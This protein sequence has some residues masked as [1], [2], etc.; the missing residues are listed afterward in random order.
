[1]TQKYVFLSLSSLIARY[2]CE[3]VQNS[4]NDFIPCLNDE[5]VQF[6][7]NKAIAMELRD[8]SRTY[9]AVSKTDEAILGFVTIG[10]KCMRVPE[11]NML[12]NSVLKQMNIE[13]STGVSQAYLL[14]QLARSK[15]SPE[16]FGDKLIDYALKLFCKAKTIV[17][18]RMVRLDCSDNLIQYYERH[19]FKLISKNHDKDLNQMMILI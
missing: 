15:G 1:M 16:G 12:S 10:L 2:G 7:S 17:G 4:L 9:L 19:G 11:E 6:I 18:C 3:K 13:E 8:L 5:T 14:G